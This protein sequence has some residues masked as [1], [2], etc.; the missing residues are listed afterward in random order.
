MK[1]FAWFLARLATAYIVASI[2]FI[3]VLEVGLL[4]TGVIASGSLIDVLLKLI[5]GAITASIFLNKSLFN[6]FKV[7]GTI[8]LYSIAAFIVFYLGILTVVLPY[9]VTKTPN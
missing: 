2:L 8:A 5:F 1:G 9:I 6:W 3:G 4:K 7:T